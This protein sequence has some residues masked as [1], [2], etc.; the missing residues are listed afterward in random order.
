MSVSGVEQNLMYLSHTGGA[1]EQGRWNL[2]LKNKK[3][4]IIIIREE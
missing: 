4:V 2:P 3:I 1:Q